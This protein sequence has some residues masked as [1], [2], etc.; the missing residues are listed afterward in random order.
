[1][2][3]ISMSDS[4]RIIVLR[5]LGRRHGES[6]RLFLSMY[7]FF[8]HIIP[9]RIK[10]W[11]TSYVLDMYNVK[12]KLQSHVLEMLCYYPLPGAAP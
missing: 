2:C 7:T 11:I 3:K 8:L 6:N 4:I 1:M 12:Q 9:Y 5:I 10:S